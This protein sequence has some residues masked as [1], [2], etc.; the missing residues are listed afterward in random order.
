M[1]LH[2]L[3][4]GTEAGGPVLWPNVYRTERTT[5]PD[6]LAIAPRREPLEVMCVLAEAIGPEYFALYV[7]SVARSDCAPGRYESPPLQLVDVRIFVAEY[8]AMLENDA[9]HE[10]WIG[11]TTGR[12]MLVYD[13]HGLIYAYGPLDDLRRSLLGMGFSE[14]KISIP[15]PHTHHFHSEYDDDVRRLLSHW[16]WRHTQLRPEDER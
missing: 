9:R 14:G 8:S 13:E 6:R 2:K 3:T 12:G 15:A 4:H 7:H 1:S 11:S 5:G 16:E 10:L